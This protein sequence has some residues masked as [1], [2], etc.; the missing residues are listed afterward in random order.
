MISTST[1]PDHVLVSGNTNSFVAEKSMAE[2]FKA[3]LMIFTQS[4]SIQIQVD[5]L[6]VSYVM[7]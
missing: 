6:F 3:D 1:F 7:Q 4:H 2:L 5:G